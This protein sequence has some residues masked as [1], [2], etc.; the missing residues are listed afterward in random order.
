MDT[1]NPFPAHPPE[2]LAAHARL[3]AGVVGYATGASPA[4][5]LAAPRGRADVASARQLA[6]YLLHGVFAASLAH[7]AVIF[8][9]DRTTVTHNLRLIEERREDAA[10]NDWVESLEDMLRAAPAP[11]AVAAEDLGAAP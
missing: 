7:V 11:N 3:V 10:Y 9:R 5:I 2:R 1:S 4:R 8:A 6:M